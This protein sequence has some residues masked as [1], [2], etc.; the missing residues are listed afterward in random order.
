MTITVIYNQIYQAIAKN[1]VNQ[2]MIITPC[3]IDVIIKLIMKR[4]TKNTTLVVRS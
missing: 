2:E 1:G 3:T 4:K